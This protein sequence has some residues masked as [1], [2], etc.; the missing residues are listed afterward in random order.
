MYIPQKDQ[1]FLI[2]LLDYARWTLDHA[3]DINY[4]RSRFDASLLH[5]HAILRCITGV[6]E[7]ASKL[8]KDT[9]KTLSRIPWQDII[10]TRHNLSHNYLEVD[11]DIIWRIVTQRFPEL[12][13]ALEPV[14]DGN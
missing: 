4:D 6:G 9:K 5:Q 14:V 7:L 8:E 2:H 12:I 3:Q 13:E 11:L 10:D 1:E